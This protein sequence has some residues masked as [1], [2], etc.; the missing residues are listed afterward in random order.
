MKLPPYTH[1]CPLSPD[2][3]FTSPDVCQKLRAR[4]RVEPY[5]P[6][7]RLCLA[8]QGPRE[9]PQ[10]LAVKGLEPMPPLQ[11]RPS[12]GAIKGGDA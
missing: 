4:A 6:G 2:R 7:R 3:K 8:C 10:P 9:L 11:H 12:L 1:F 5:M